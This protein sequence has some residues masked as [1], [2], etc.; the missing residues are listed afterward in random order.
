MIETIILEYLSEKLDVPVYMEE[1]DDRPDTYVTI[2][3]TGSSRTNLIN[4]ATLAIQSYAATMHEA[5]QL[6]ETVKEVLD[7][8][9]ELSSVS[10]AELNS[11]YN[12]TDTSTKRYRYQAVYDFVYFKEE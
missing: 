10:R 11:D 4:H 12:Y 6:N 5:A 7:A 8:S 1:P 2:E 9:I 3:K